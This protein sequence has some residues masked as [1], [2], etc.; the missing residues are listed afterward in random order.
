MNG[1]ARCTSTSV[2]A[3]RPGRPFLIVGHPENRRIDMFLAALHSRGQP[4]ATVVAH[5]DALRHGALAALPDRPFL[6][7]L[8]AMGESAECERALLGL[9]YDEAMAAGVSTVSPRALAEMPVENGRILAPRQVHFGFLRYLDQLRNV[10]ARRP[11]WRV[12]TPPDSIEELF[13][14]RLT[15]RRYAAAGIPVP[16]SLAGV[17]TPAELRDAMRDAGWRSVFVKLTC[18]SS[19]SCLAVYQLSD[20]GR[21]VVMT[22]IRR[23]PR[24]W[25]NSLKVQR[26]DDRE[27]IDEIL[28][29]LLREGSQVEKTVPKARLDGAFMDCRVLVIDGEPAFVVVRQNRHPITNLH[30]GGWRGDFAALR[31]AVPAEAWEAAMESCRRVFA[32]HRCFHLGVD[33]LFEPGFRRHRIL[34]ANA[35]GDLLPRLTRRGL[36]VYEW[37]IDRLARLPDRD[38]TR[39]AARSSAPG[40]PG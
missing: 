2:S 33:L 16:E 4:P 12:L 7:R 39:S 27:G 11:R 23:T 40:R 31:R 26:V 1:M 28:G 14:K 15:S 6:V 8:D 36:N 34:E 18:G 38:S 9:G 29:F 20:S 17:T 24:G 35:F 10:F 22:T 30:L 25:F 19:A 5:L 13:D 21:G 37:Q 3:S 32:S